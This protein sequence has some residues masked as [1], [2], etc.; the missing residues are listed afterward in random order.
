MYLPLVY[1]P[2]RISQMTKWKCHRCV[3]L[4]APSKFH[5]FFPV[6]CSDS[7]IRNAIDCSSK[8]FIKIS[9]HFLFWLNRRGACTL[10]KL[11]RIFNNIFIITVFFLNLWVSQFPRIHQWLVIL[12]TLTFPLI[13][14]IL[15]VTYTL[16]WWLPIG[17]KLYNRLYPLYIKIYICHPK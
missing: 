11:F 15:N 3:I 14:N 6:Q 4:T 5:V 9:F 17:L 12:I 1:F 7:T 13:E 10:K 8:I 16:A 2:L